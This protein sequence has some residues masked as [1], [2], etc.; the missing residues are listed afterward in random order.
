ML[1]EKLI[2]VICDELGVDENDIN[3]DTL[4]EELVGDELETED[5]VITLEREFGVEFGSELSGD[6]SIAELAEMIEE[7]D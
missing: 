7:A 2:S 6:I 5:L 3:E 1:L 4:L